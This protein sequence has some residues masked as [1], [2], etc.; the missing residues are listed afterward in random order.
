MNNFPFHVLNPSLGDS[1]CSL[2]RLSINDL[3][4]SYVSWLNEPEVTKHSECRFTAHTFQTVGEHISRLFR[5]DNYELLLGIFIEHGSRYFA[6]VKTWPISQHHNHA[7]VG[8][9]IGDQ[10]F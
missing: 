3:S 4:A 6:S 9:M 5:L 2:R 10:T 8:I 7:D 1:T